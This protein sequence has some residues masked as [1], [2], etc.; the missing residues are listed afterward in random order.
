MRVRKVK[1]RGCRRNGSQKRGMG[2]GKEEKGKAEDWVEVW[3]GVE[4]KRQS[5]GAGEWAGKEKAAGLLLGKP[6][7]PPRLLSHDPKPLACTLL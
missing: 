2:A 3:G 4:C 6:H 7:K 5:V 1:C